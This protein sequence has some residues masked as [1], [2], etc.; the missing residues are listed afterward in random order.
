MNV[1]AFIKHERCPPAL[2]EL[3]R[4]LATNRKREQGEL[5]RL[6]ATDKYGPWLPFVAWRLVSF[7]RLDSRFFV[8][9]AFS[10]A[11]ILYYLFSCTSPAV[12]ATLILCAISVIELAFSLSSLRPLVRKKPIPSKHTAQTFSPALLALPEV[13]RALEETT[14]PGRGD[15]IYD[16]V[17]PGLRWLLDCA[18][19]PAS[20][21]V[22]GG[23]AKGL[24]ANRP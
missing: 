17:V 2:A 24:M 19:T 12:S 22:A 3:G 15:E 13:A 6:S 1:Q 20:M 21:L 23:W 7:S 9:F 4:S 8:P 18:H 11:S 5:A 10:L 16:N 14:F